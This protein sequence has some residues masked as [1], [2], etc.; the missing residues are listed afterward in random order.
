MTIDETPL[1]AWADGAHRSRKAVMITWLVLALGLV[2]FASL[3]HALSGAMWEVKGSDSLAARNII[4]EQFGGFNGVAVCSHRDPQRH[5]CGRSPGVPRGD[6]ADANAVLETEEAFGPAMPAMPGMDSHTVMIQAGAVVDPTEAVKAAER[7]HDAV[8]EL[9]TVDDG[10]DLTVAL[11]GSPAFWGDFSAVNRGH[12][13]GRDPDLAGHGRDS[14]PCLRDARCRWTPAADG[15]RSRRVDGR[16]VRDHPV[17]RPVDL[18]PQL[19][20]DVRPRA[21]DRLRC[22]SSPGSRPCMHSP[23][24]SSTLSGSP[25]TPQARR[26]SSPA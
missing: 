7:I 23:T 10:G 12:D 2:V 16:A 14:R 3:E 21:G 15:R 11:T 18:D 19:R 1:A 13:E 4:D 6:V 5:A 8:G 25:W 22:S 17:H 20:H 26:C 9:S 24:R